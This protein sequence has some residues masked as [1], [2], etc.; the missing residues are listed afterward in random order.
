M[1]TTP[2]TL[3]PDR[4]TVICDDWHDFFL[5]RQVYQARVCFD[6]RPTSIRCMHNHTSPEA[7]AKCCR[8]LL[9]E[10]SDLLPQVTGVTVVSDDLFDACAD[11]TPL[12]RFYWKDQNPHR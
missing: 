1:T 8:N 6:Q 4:M 7:T 10:F 12:F 3:S 2:T 9:R 5:D 11:T